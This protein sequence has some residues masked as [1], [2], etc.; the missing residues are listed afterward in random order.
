[1]LSAPSGFSCIM[2]GVTPTSVRR[3]GDLDDVSAAEWLPGLSSVCVCESVS[4]RERESDQSTCTAHRWQMIYGARERG[5]LLRYVAG[6]SGGRRP[7]DV[8]YQV[9]HMP[10][11]TCATPERVVCA[12]SPY[13]RRLMGGLTLWRRTHVYTSRHQSRSLTEST[14]RIAPRTTNGH[15]PLPNGSRKSSAACLS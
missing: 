2:R 6:T 1:M 8:C 12:H 15:A 11:Q 3:G 5:E 10:N 9:T 7:P 14:R 13:C 4:E